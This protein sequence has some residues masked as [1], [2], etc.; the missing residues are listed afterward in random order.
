MFSIITFNGVVFTTFTVL[1][2]CV[3][4]YFHRREKV[5]PKSCFKS[6]SSMI[7]YSRITSIIWHHCH[8]NKSARIRKAPHENAD[9]LQSKVSQATPDGRRILSRGR[10][11]ADASHSRLC[12]P[13]PRFP[14]C[15]CPCVQWIVRRPECQALPRVWSPGGSVCSLHG[16]SWGVTSLHIWRV[17]HAFF[18]VFFFL[19]L[20]L[21]F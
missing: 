9:R 1:I 11:D 21:S 17:T 10:V 18:N 19:S 15:P 7:E 12:L 2:V 20:S 5:L 4:V 6:Y 16:R 8:G 14:A 13:R 3:L